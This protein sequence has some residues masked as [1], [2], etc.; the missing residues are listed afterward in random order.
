MTSKWPIDPGGGQSTNRIHR[1][2]NSSSGDVADDVDG[3]VAANDLAVARGPG[4][5]VW[6]KGQKRF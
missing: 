2:D 4:S 1:K 6:S 3:D 5:T